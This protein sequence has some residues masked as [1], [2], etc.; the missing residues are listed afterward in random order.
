MKQF[1][2]DVNDNEGN[3]ETNATESEIIT[4]LKRIEHKIDN[5]EMRL[6][7]SECKQTL[8]TEELNKFKS[9]ISTISE[10]P[11]AV[12]KRE[13][14][15]KKLKTKLKASSKTEKRLKLPCTSHE[16]L[17]AVENEIRENVGAY[18]CIVRF[19]NIYLVLNY[20][21][22]NYYFQYQY[23]HRFRVTDEAKFVRSCLHHIFDEYL[24]TQ[25]N[26]SGLG[27]KKKR[28]AADLHIMKVVKG[29]FDHFL[30]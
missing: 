3:D 1:T 26:W 25:Y 17:M 13:S 10:L 18:N 5:I 29:K 14:K 23:L 22:K 8:F 12:I 6:Q 19:C 30:Y 11:N 9:E 21:I 20:L 4:I 16:E 28:S 27:E 24:A 2:Q 7:D 15:S